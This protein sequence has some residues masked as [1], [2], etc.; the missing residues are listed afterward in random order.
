MYIV[1]SARELCGWR[2]DLGLRLILFDMRGVGGDAFPVKIA[3]PNPPPVVVGVEQ[4]D[5]PV[6]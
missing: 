2:A 5:D 4:C 6:R 1:H 3:L